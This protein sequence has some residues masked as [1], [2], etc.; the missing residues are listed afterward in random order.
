MLNNFPLFVGVCGAVGLFFFFVLAS[1]SLGHA[2]HFVSALRG[3]LLQV[4]RHL[5]VHTVHVSPNIKL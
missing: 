4:V 5:T 3:S 2:L 1:D